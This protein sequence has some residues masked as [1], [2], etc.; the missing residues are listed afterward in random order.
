MVPALMMGR[1]KYSQMIAIN[2]K[3]NT[4]TPK[5]DNWLFFAI[6]IAH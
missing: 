4:I 1:V 2:N 3:G 5:H 6:P